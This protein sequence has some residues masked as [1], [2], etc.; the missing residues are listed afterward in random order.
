MRQK[1]NRQQSLFPPVP[2]RS[3]LESETIYEIVLRLRAAGCHV[4]RAGTNH[5]VDG[6]SLST[7]Q[8]ADM[9]LRLSPPGEP[10]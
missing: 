4:T 9:A 3:R 8:L 6:K 2:Q 7:A 10:G 1:S 5:I